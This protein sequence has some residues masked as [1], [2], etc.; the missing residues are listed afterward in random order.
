VRHR[1]N[2]STQAA[3]LIQLFVGSFSGASMQS[4][5]LNCL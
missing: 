4:D 3:D 5:T 1:F 2:E